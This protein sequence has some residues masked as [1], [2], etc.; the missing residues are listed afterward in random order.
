MDIRQTKEGRRA[1]GGIATDRPLEPTDY[2]L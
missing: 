2:T 1:I